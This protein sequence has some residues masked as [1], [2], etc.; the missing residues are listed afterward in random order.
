MSRTPGRMPMAMAAAA[1]AMKPSTTTGMRSDAPP[2]MSPL[3]AASSGPPTLA[4]TSTASLGLGRLIAMPRRMRPAL[5]R[6]RSEGMPEPMPVTSSTDAPVSTA[7]MAEE[8]EVLPM[9]ISPA[10]SR[11]TP[12]AASSRAM[13]MPTC[14]QANASSRVMAG[15]SLKS[16]A[17]CMTL[18]RTS[19]S[20]SSRSFF[21]P[22]STTE[23]RAPAL[24][25]KAF[26][27]PPPL[28]KLRTCISVT[29]CPVALTP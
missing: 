7:A 8:G 1:P 22:T 18:R 28:T 21:T 13:S 5:W 10:A 3:M 25:Q 29:S 4:S 12:R 20:T 19:P 11:V 6:T 14:T 2:S 24:R 16:R 23:S 15:P 9:P 17:A 27:V 26:I